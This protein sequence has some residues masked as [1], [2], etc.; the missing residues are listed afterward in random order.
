MSLVKISDYSEAPEDA[1]G[2]TISLEHPY[3]L[4]KYELA[5]F[6]AEG[7]F[8]AITDKCTK[9]AGSL[10]RGVLRGKFAVCTNQECLWNIQKGYCKFDRSSVLPTYKVQEKEDGLYI[11]I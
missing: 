5:L 6:K 10:G 11:E 4:Y 9:C 3:T 7:K 2:K 1:C 8:F